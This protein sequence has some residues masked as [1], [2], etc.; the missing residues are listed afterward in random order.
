M[1]NVMNDIDTEIVSSH[2]TSEGLIVYSRVDGVLEVRLEPYAG[3]AE[4]IAE[5][6]ANRARC[7]R[8]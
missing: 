4:V 7:S 5:A 8:R 3:P 6:P 1:V 2:R